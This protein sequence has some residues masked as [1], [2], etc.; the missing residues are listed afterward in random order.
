MAANIDPG[1]LAK[2]PIYMGVEEYLTGL[3]EEYNNLIAS[4]DANLEYGMLDIEISTGLD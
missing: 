2:D 1:T 4:R 3:E